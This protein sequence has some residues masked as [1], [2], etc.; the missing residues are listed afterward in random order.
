MLTFVLGTAGDES[1]KSARI[2]EVLAVA[3]GVGLAAITLIAGQRGEKTSPAPGGILSRHYDEGEK[4]IYHMTGSNQ[5]W[6]YKIDANG[7]VKKDADGKFYEEY[8][9]SEMISDGAAYSLP[10][11]S[12]QFHQKLSLESDTSPS[13]P[14][15]SHVD[16]KIIGP[17]TDLLTVYS[18]LWLANKMGLFSKAGDHFYF[19]R[20]TPNSWA[21]GN[22]VLLGQ[23]SIDFD[24]T[25]TK[26]DQANQTATL[27]VRHLPPQNP[28]I[29]ISVDWMRA[30]V[31]DTPNNWVEVEKHGEKKIV[32]EV[33]KETFEAE[34]NV[35]L[36]N[37]KIIS[38][39]IDNPV[40]VL[41]RDCEDVELSRCSE[42]KRFQIRRQIE[43][44]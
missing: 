9:W 3:A 15:L 11:A 27:V 25:L 23:D 21:D 31:A 36:K 8:A 39:T 24:L 14:D 29:K 28:Q 12:Q 16:P 38:A 20:S 35:S 4:L 43:I 34:I 13:V 2:A 44:K 26:V 6:H 41:S 18:D 42:P 10:E 37:G 5:Q 22:Y 30:P 19:K 17:I 33:G 40:E 7:V 32:A 1:M